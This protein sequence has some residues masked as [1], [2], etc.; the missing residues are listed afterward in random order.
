MRASIGLMFARDVQNPYRRLGDVLLLRAAWSVA[1]V[2]MVVVPAL[3]LGHRWGGWLLAAGALWAL[4]SLALRSAPPATR[5]ALTLSAISTV[6]L[7]CAA[8]CI[9]LSGGAGGAASLLLLWPVLIAGLVW[10]P[11]AGIL[12]AALG[13][14][15]HTALALLEREAWPAPDLLQLVGLSLTGGWPAAAFTAVNLLGAALLV[16]LLTGDLVH[17]NLRLQGARRDMELRVASARLA[18]Q[19]LETVKEWGGLL[20]RS[21]ELEVLLPA[22]LRFLVEHLGF[23]AGLVVLQGASED[24]GSIAAR[25]GVDEQECTGL[26]HIRPES[27]EEQGGVAGNGGVG[28]AG[29]AETRAFPLGLADAPLGMVYLFGRE[30]APGGKVN[31]DELPNALV[32]ELALAVRNA[33]F[34]QELK[35]THDDLLRLDRLKNDFLATMSHELRTPLTSIIG[36]TDMM[37]SGMAGE[38]GNAQKTY[39][40]A[41]LNS[42]EALLSLINDLLDLTKIQAGRMDLRLAPVDLSTAVAASLAVVEPQ[43]RERRIRLC[44]TVPSTLPPVLADPARLEQI[45]VNLLSNA[46]KFSPEH[47]P[48]GIEGRS[49][50]PG[51]VEVL[52]TDKGQGIAEEDAGR[53]FE[54]FSQLDSDS[55]RRH[56]GTGLGLAITRDLVELHGGS[57]TVRSQPRAGST[58]AFTIPQALS[59]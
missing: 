27:R 38:V 11:R 49:L 23:D 39:L 25:L 40:R 48:V 20:G 2:G 54:R 37:L 34:G 18:E 19:R 17:A 45:L 51:W 32:A 22:A 26:L 42:S 24:R 14:S 55:T 21:Q 53:I 3:S 57:I 52:V 58:F 59:A 31:D 4:S 43:A 8:V 35:T 16:A 41:V 56:G 10:G 5:E 36:Y 44:T 50:T 29:F 1:A 12:T 7:A 30:S 13:V 46:I 47:A 9:H 15:A 33:Q 28:I 6:D